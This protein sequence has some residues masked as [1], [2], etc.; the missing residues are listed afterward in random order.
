MNSLESLDKISKTTQGVYCLYNKNRDKYYIGSA[1]DVIKR[2]KTHRFE[3][4]NGSHDNRHLQSDFD[5]DG[6][7]AFEFEILEK[8]IPTELLTSYE[9]YW[10]YE[11]KAIVMYVGYNKIFP[12]SN[13]SNF[14][15]VYDL[16]EGKIMDE[17]VYAT[18]TE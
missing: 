12:T 10:I 7:D 15:Y 14:R 17:E 5:S 4:L 2:L 9:K 13:Y 8:D 11:K 3:L 6:I 1:K 18:S 16:K